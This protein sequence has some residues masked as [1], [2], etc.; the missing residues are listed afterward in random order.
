MLISHPLQVCDA[1]IGFHPFTGSDYTPSFKDKGKVRPLKIMQSNKSYMQAFK[2]LG[3]S[4]VI[5]ADT[6]KILEKFV[7]QVYGDKKCESVNELRYKKFVK[8]EETL[9]CNPIFI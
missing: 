8:E 5:Q 4:E 9:C 7:C 2:D 6:L 1:L 3:S